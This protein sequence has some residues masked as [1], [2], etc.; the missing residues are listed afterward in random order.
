MKQLEGDEVALR[1]VQTAGLLNEEGRIHPK[2]VQLLRSSMMAL[3]LERPLHQ[4]LCHC[5]RSVRSNLISTLFQIASSLRSS[6]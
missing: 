6:Q 4:T 2:G 1:G 5:E 3:S